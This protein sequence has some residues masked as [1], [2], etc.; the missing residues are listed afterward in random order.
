M[1]S[2]WMGVLVNAGIAVIIGFF[3]R[4]SIL[5]DSRQQEARRQREQV[6]QLEE[7]RRRDAARVAA[8][9]AVPSGCPA[10]GT[11][12]AE[13]GWHPADLLADLA[14]EI[15]ELEAELAAARKERD[16]LRKQLAGPTPAV[17]SGA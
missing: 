13:A 4:R 14:D 8:R 9:A 2:Y 1:S 17:S 15:D 3:W 12:P 11:G 10:V 7:E 5:R 16:E 6:A